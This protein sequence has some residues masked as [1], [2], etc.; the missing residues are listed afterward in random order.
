MTRKIF[1]PFGIS[2]L[3]LVSC[4]A[5]REQKPNII[6]IL[7]D[8]LGYGDIS[9]LGQE[10][11]DTPNIDRLISQGM[12]F[13]DHYAG[14]A[15]SAPSRSCLV[16]GLHTGHTP[17][18]GN[19]ELTPDEG[20][21]PL[22]ED[23]YTI[24]D[25]F[26]ENGYA[27]GVFGKWGL[28]GPGTEGTPECHGVD[29]FYGYNCQRYAHNYYPLHIWHN[30]RKIILEENAGKGEG[31]Y[32]PGLIHKAALSFM[33]GNKDRPFFLWYTTNIPH[34]ELRLPE[35]ELEE[36][37]GRE[38]LQ[39]EKKYEG[40][41]DSPEYK[42]GGYGSQE[43]PHAAFAAMITLL[44]R[45]VGEISDMLDSLG[46][47]DNTILIFS[48][49]NGAHMEGGAD[50]DFFNSNGIYRGYK[51]DLYEGGIRTPMAIRW[52]AKVK[53]GSTSS[54]ISAF[55]DFMPTFA[56]AIG[57]EIP[58]N[59]DGISFLPSLTG[60]GEQK[61]HEYLYWEFHEYGGR[62]AVRKGVWKAVR[63]NVETDGEIQ[64]Y[65]LEDDPG[66]STDLAGQYPAMVAEFDGLMEG[67]RT[68]SD[69]FPWKRTD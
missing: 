45:Q 35:E 18:R 61:E 56:E 65:N 1:I 9:A 42:Y 57:A 47:A 40:G 20:Q 59:I 25:M 48:S 31:Q 54:L 10:H 2:A 32:A 16:T 44:D 28:G 11:F 6:F 49:D 26:K 8:D 12:F 5:N 29:E 64:L 58:E 3:S 27:T 30:S 50:P 67:A 34:A 52:P 43:Y 19:M 15:V 46:I 63:Y 14:A 38:D 62:Q 53:A 39:P 41:E 13:T 17:I 36:F 7:A 24:F 23:T 66:E 60:V 55:W 33:E 22:P 68:E 37:A 51:R 4:S 21:Y 69:L